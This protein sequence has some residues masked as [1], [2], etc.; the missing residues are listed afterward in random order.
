MKD[1]AEYGKRFKTFYNKLKRGSGAKERRDPLPIIEEFIVAILARETTET[2]ALAAYKR[3]IENVVDLNELR[4]TTS[5]EMAA[6]VGESFP[7]CKEKAEEISSVL[8][9]IVAREGRLDL[10]GLKQKK[11]REAREYLETLGGATPFAAAWVLSRCLGGHAVPVDHALI[12]AL[13]ADDMVAPD[14]ELPEIQAFLERIIPAAD[15]KRNPGMLRDYAT[16]RTKTSKKPAERPAKTASK[17]KA[18]RRTAAQTKT[19]RR[20][21]TKSRPK[22]PPTKRKTTARR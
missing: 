19:K 17:K 15:F 18:T 8:N 16:Q 13:K 6:F 9:D 22:K 3:L 4:V 11:V 12:R 14:S 20:T 7:E 1:G 2:Q 21:T 5:R 10:G